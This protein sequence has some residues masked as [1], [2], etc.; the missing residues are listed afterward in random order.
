MFY[1]ERGLNASNLKLTFNFPQQNTLRVTKE[2]DTSGVNELF[3]DAMENLGSFEIELQTMATS[4]IPLDVKNSAGYVQTESK[5]LYTPTDGTGG[6]FEQP[7]IARRR[8][9]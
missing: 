3:A 4:G 6:T 5:A 2:V 8:L 7:D 9:R 1:M